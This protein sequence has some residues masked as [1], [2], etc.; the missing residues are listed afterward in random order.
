MQS[1]NGGLK[2]KTTFEKIKTKITQAPTL[3]SLEFNR[4][5]IL[6]MFVSNIAFVVVLTQK[7]PDGN[8]YP[9]VFMSSRVA[10]SRVRLSQS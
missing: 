10:R 2:R 7:D 1:L 8:E 6:Y 4:D 3:M 5:F 9:I